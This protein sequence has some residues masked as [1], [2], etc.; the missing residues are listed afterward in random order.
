MSGLTPEQIERLDGGVREWEDRGGPILNALAPVVAAL[1]AEAVE[2]ARAEERE[3]VINAPVVVGRMDAY[4]YTFKRTGVPTIDAILSAVAQA[5]KSYHHTESWANDD[6]YL[7][8]SCE[9][10]IQAAADL[11]ARIAR[12]EVSP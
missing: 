12:G 7:S 11:A 8:P 9:A 2:Q 3:R 5:G 4:Y 6:E 10:R 1:I